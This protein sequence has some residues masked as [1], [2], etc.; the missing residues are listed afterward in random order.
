LYGKTR[1]FFLIFPSLL[2][3]GLKTAETALRMIT[4]A[5]IP[6]RP[7]GGV[8]GFVAAAGYRIRRYGTALIASLFAP[9]QTEAAKPVQAMP[10]IR[11]KGLQAIA[12]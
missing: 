8:Y 1:R 9:P 6:N 5:G 7:R 3:V 11:A 12:A 2:P 10:R 4:S